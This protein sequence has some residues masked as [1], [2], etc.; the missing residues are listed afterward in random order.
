MSGIGSA[1]A[2]LVLAL[3]LYASILPL[4]LAG[5]AAVAM[6]T[7]SQAVVRAIYEVNQLYESTFHLDLYRACIAHHRAL[8]AERGTV[9]WDG[10]D[11]STVDADEALLRDA[12]SGSGTDSVVA[13]LPDGCPTVRPR[14]FQGG[15]DLSGGQWQRVAVARGP[16]PGRPPGHRGRAHRR[17]GRPRRARRV[18][19]AARADRSGVGPDHRAG[20]PPAG[21]RPHRRPDRRAG[22]RTDHRAGPPRR[23]DGA[24]GTYHELFSLQARAY[25]ADRGTH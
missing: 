23:A 5:A 14:E 11:V 12:A 19:H 4:A 2:Y 7:A 21:Q 1:G 8:P 9:R 22:A 6:R 16:V 3:L 18:R 20:H 15:R 13:E 17:A 25:A 24:R 10:V